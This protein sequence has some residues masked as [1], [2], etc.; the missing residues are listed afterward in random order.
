MP[1]QHNRC[2][3]LPFL[4][5]QITERR[6]KCPNFLRMYSKVSKSSSETLLEQQIT[7][8]E[9]VPIFISENH[10]VITMNSNVIATKYICE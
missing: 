1:F 3:N 4:V 10:Q 6:Q 5:L 2:Y 7:S 9:E 8:S